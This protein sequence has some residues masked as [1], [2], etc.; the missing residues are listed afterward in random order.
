MLELRRALGQRQQLVDLL[1]V[2]GEHQF[3]LAIG[4]E[5]GGFLIQHVAVEAETHRADRVDGDLGGDPVR[6]VVADDADHVA[7]A[8]PERDHAEREVAHSVLVVLPGELPPQPEI[9][10][11]QRDFAAVLMGVEPQQ[12]RKG[13][14]FGDATGVVHHAACSATGGWSGASSGSTRSSSSSPR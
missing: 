7:A 11:T 14:G 3:G 2:L 8:E 1:L 9:F 12:L 6:A 10:L 13:V 4:Q 5:I